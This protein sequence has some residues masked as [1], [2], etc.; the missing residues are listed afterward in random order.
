MTANG[1]EPLLSARN[2]VQ[3]FV[4]RGHGGVKG[5]VV[6]AVSDVSFDVR[7]G[8][9]MGVMGANG[10]GKSTLMRTVAGI[11]PPLSGRI[12][13][14]LD[15]SCLVEH[16]SP[17][18]HSL[19]RSAAHDIERN[20]LLDRSQ[21]QQALFETFVRADDSHLIPVREMEASLALTEARNK[22]DVAAIAK[23]EAALAA[24]QK[25]KA[26]RPAA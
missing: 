13:G 7:R 24:V 23:A 22:G 4:V 26:A 25:E 21:C 1:D 16:S 19:V 3:E 5:G 6:Q 14:V 10:A 20:L 2:V 12:E 9:V 11:L 17:L 18:M 15:I 8:S